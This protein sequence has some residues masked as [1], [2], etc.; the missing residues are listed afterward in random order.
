M[1]GLETD[2]EGF[3]R[4][5]RGAVR[6][7]ARDGGLATLVYSL[8]DLCQRGA[9]MLL[10]VLIQARCAGQLRMQLRERMC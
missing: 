2:R 6:P 3:K 4:V 1:V 10:G 5:C 8:F 7:T 9:Q